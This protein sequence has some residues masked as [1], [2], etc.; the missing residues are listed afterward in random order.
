MESGEK[1]RWYQAALSV[2]YS[3][4]VTK[5][6]NG[7]KRVHFTRKTVLCCAL[8]ALVSGCASTPI[9]KTAEVPAGSEIVIIPFRDCL[10][11]GQDEDCNGSGVTAG[12]AFREAFAEGGKFTSR[13]A[14]RP[15]GP[16]ESL[17]DQAAAE[18]ARRNNYA[19]VI[20]GE[21][22]DFYSVA[23]MTFRSDRA[24]VTTRLI[25]ASDGQVITTFSKRG[26]AG[27]NFATPKGMI[28]DIATELRNGL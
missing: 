6:L 1:V 3:S 15:V 2:C 11:S 18:F 21:V 12:E 10:I 25:R 27:S 26:S 28:K 20:N 4:A 14:E 23:A 9:T 17:S 7:G 5:K 16:K 8:I 13:L 19:Y 24:A 22:D